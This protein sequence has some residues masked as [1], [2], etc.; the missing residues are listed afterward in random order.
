MDLMI[1]TTKIMV[2]IPSLII[3][4]FFEAHL[5]KTDV[6]VWGTGNALREFTFSDDAARIIWWASKNYNEVTPINIGNTEEISIGDLANT[7]GKI[8]GFRGKI[9]FDTT[10]PEGQ[11]R[12]PTSNAKLLSF[13]CNPRYTSL[14]EGLTRTIH[15][16][17]KCYPNVRGMK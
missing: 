2:V 16:F 12:K 14:E 5:E 6:T 9:R 3:R 7:I 4:K 15:H 11:H 13:D 17:T 8:I 1:I 10:K